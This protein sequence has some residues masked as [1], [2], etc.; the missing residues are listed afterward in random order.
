M[1]LTHKTHFSINESVYSE[2]N[3]KKGLVNFRANL[4]SENNNVQMA[5]PA[6]SICVMLVK[7]I[8]H[9]VLIKVKCR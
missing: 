1:S 8:C 7:S 3:T 5:P 2:G 9:F 6:L 4:I